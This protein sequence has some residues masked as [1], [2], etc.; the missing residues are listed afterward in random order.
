MHLPGLTRG[1]TYASCL[2]FICGDS[3]F[4]LFLSLVCLAKDLFFFQHFFVNAHLS[5]PCFKRH[6]VPAFCFHAEPIKATT[7]FQVFHL[8]MMLVPE[9]A[10]GA[11]PCD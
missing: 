1:T 8:L 11:C 6:Q 3:L 9:E 2:M 4:D 7:T 10:G 5:A